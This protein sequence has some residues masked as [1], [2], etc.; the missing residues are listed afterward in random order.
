MTATSPRIRMPEPQPRPMLP[1]FDVFKLAKTAAI[2]WGRLTPETFNR[3][4]YDVLYWRDM[5]TLFCRDQLHM[6]Y[7]QIGRRLERD[8]SAIQFAL[9]RARQRI[10]SDPAYAEAYARFERDVLAHWNARTMP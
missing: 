8:Q 9:K 6:S 5:V 4:S 1:K 7:P 3:K 2:K 10:A